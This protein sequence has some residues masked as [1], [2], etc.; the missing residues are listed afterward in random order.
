MR[1]RNRWPLVVLIATSVV[2]IGTGVAVPAPEEAGWLAA[3]PAPGG[4][5]TCGSCMNCE[6]PGR[7]ELEAGTGPDDAKDESDHS[8]ASSEGAG[9]CP[10]VHEEA[11]TC[12][13]PGPLAPVAQ[14]S[15]E[16]HQRLWALVATDAGV[17]ADL[18][19]EL[20][21]LGEA[22]V[23]NRN[24]GAV[25]VH[26]GCDGSLITMSIPLNAEQIGMLEATDK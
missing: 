2:M 11:V 21:E 25:Q 4:P 17:G 20:E 3:L 12:F 13:G 8:C 26:G 23:F 5:P 14:L 9:S 16:G 19:A 22:V 18:A 1:S 24:R 7:H 6:D 15:L 10:D